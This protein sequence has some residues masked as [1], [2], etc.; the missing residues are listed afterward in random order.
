MAALDQGG[1]SYDTP[2]P[3]GLLHQAVVR[4]LPLVPTSL[5]RRLSAR[6]I[7][8]ETLDSALRLS[9]IHI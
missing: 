4:T 6:Y 2:A 3:M 8:G 7:A 1:G 5:M 9:L